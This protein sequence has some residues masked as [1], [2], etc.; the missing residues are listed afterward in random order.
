[1]LDLSGVEN[2][3]AASF[4]LLTLVGVPNPEGT[5]LVAFE[6]R[7]ASILH[8]R[9]RLILDMKTRATWLFDQERDPSEQK[10]LS[11]ELPAITSRMVKELAGWQK[12]SLPAR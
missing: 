9:Y 5:T 2:G 11:G 10:N 4:S 8:G 7:H 12:V 1:L 6:A 3:A